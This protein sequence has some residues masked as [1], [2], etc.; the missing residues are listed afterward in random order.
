MTDV[1]RIS[2]LSGKAWLHVAAIY[3]V[4][5]S[6][7]RGTAGKFFGVTS[8]K[9][10]RHSTLNNLGL[11]SA[12]LRKMCKPILMV[13]AA[14][15][16]AQKAKLIINT[17]YKQ[18]STSAYNGIASAPRGKT[19]RV[20]DLSIWIMLSFLFL[21]HWTSQLVILLIG[22]TFITFAAFNKEVSP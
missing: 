16:I 13:N 4:G 2:P 19:G 20:N 10:R 1:G 17:K 14:I 3:S 8:G 6:K 15:A 5:G 22:P 18:I 7:Y 21:A 9:Y 11:Y 12:S